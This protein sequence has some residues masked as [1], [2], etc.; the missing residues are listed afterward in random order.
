L[1][2]P[3]L[4]IHGVAN[5]DRNAFEALAR[6]LA[7]DIGGV[8]PIAAFWGDL[9]AEVD[10]LRETIPAMG[11]AMVRSTEP[12]DEWAASLALS[13]LEGS[14]AAP[15]EE[16]TTVRSVPSAQRA[17][18]VADAVA[19]RGGAADVRGAETSEAR[20]EVETIWPTT[21]WLSQI[22]DEAVLQRL[23]EAI[24]EAAEL[25]DEAEG[26]EVRG[27]RDGFRKTVRGVVHGLDVAVGA[28]VGT[29][30]QGLDTF[31]RRKAA[32]GFASFV[33]DVFVYQA[34]RAEIH[35]RVRS[36]LRAADGDL[37]TEERPVAVLGHSLGG[38]IAFDLA[39]AGEPRL[40][41]RPLITF[42]SQSPFFHVIDPRGGDLT[43][44]MPPDPL[45][46]PPTIP[47]WINLWEPLDPLA[48][49]AA[50]VFRLASGKAPTDL[51]VRH[52]A[53]YGLWTHS[54]YW[55]S[56]DLLRAARDELAT[57]T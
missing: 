51:E 56:D 33:G 22:G 6:Q 4:I 11:P 47:R 40:H 5:R 25:S 30:G 7:T 12:D 27:F 2:T 13:L 42:G 14:I 9:G 16:S 38:V 54:A 44:F 1:A 35:E 17:A 21:R 23:G 55:R 48:F 45:P 3:V 43:R 19:S 20:D 46:L 10:G 29:L 31:I 8:T 49:V 53:S 57:I 28:V 32:P 50:K 41:T 52:L 15:S 18:V 39:V 24:A 34:H 36:A 26:E 37:G